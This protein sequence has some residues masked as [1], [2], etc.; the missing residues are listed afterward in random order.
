[1][2]KSNTNQRKSTAGKVVSVAMDMVAVVDIEHS[3][4]HWLYGKS[5]K[6]NNRIK[7]RN[8]I[9]GLKIGD[10]VLISEIRP[11]S[12]LVHFEIVKKLEKK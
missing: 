5:Y 9:S 11:L 3:K 8:N 2:N 6:V 7:A 10:D 1:M 4:T 12:K